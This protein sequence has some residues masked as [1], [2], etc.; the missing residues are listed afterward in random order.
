MHERERWQI[1][2]AMLSER[3]QVPVTDVFLEGLREAAI[4]VEIPGHVSVAA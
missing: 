1:I 2:K 3:A 4:A